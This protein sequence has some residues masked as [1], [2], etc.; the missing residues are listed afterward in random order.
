LNIAGKRVL[1]TGGSSDTGMRQP[2]RV[3]VGVRRSRP[4]DGDRRLPR[5]ALQTLRVI[6]KRCLVSILRRAAGWSC[7]REDPEKSY[8]LGILN[9]D[10]SYG[11][12][13]TCVHPDPTGYA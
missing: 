10:P 3:W 6:A 8:G 1:I 4:L 7:R 13:F 2:A 12:S 5:R 11:S 9:R